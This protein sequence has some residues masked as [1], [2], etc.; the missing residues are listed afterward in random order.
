[1]AANAI[2]ISSS[3]RPLVSKPRTVQTKTSWL[4]LP[5]IKVGMS[6]PFIASKILQNKSQTGKDRIIR[7]RWPWIKL[8]SNPTALRFTWCFCQGRDNNL[9]IY[10]TCKH[11]PIW[12][13]PTWV[14]GILEAL[15]NQGW[16]MVIFGHNWAVHFRERLTRILLWISIMQMK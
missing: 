4:F 7:M 3:N 14:M 13:Y 9:T 6:C 5:P 11:W 15:A 12:M 2:L 1:M 16:A 10:I 8:D